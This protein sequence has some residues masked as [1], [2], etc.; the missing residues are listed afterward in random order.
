MYESK[1]RKGDTQYAIRNTL[2][3]L[4]NT[5]ICQYAVPSCVNMLYPSGGLMVLTSLRPP[6][7]ALSQ[8]TVTKRNDSET[9]K[10]VAKKKRKNCPTRTHFLP[11]LFC[12]LLCIHVVQVCVFY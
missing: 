4:V 9:K 11:M 3:N 1:S 10:S 8:V 5:L 2:G 12:S 7:R 6:Q